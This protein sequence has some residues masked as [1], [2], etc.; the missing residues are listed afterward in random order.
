VALSIAAAA[1]MAVVSLVA[2]VK[3][4]QADVQ[5]TRAE[6]EAQTATLQREA[7]LI[8]IEA[9]EN[10]T[11]AL[12]RAVAAANTNLGFDKAGGV[13]LL[14]EIR[15]SLFQALDFARELPPL[16]GFHDGGYQSVKSISIR[17]ATDASPPRVSIASDNVGLIAD[18]K[19]RVVAR[20]I[21]VP[22]LGSAYANA[23]IWTDRSAQALA[24][25]ATGLIDDNGPNNAAVGL[26][27]AAGLLQRRVLTD[28]PFPILSLATL[29]LSHALLAGDSQGSLF[30]IDLA[31]GGV[32]KVYQGFGRPLIGI[33]APDSED[34][35]MLAFGSRLEATTSDPTPSKTQ[36]EEQ[37]AK[38]IAA[39]LETPELKVY[40]IGVGADETINCIGEGAGYTILTCDGRGGVAVWKD[41]YAPAWPSF[42]LVNHISVAGGRASAVAYDQ[43]LD[44][45]A[46]GDVDGGIQIFSA[47]G[48]ALTPILR[49]PGGPI[50]ALA[51]LENG[52]L[53]L[54][55]GGDSSIRRWD[56][57][58]LG[59]REANSPQ[60]PSGGIN[61][62]V[63]NGGGT[64]VFAASESDEG[65]HVTLLELNDADGRATS[66]KF[67][68]PPKTNIRGVKL[69]VD[70]AGARAAWNEPQAIVIVDFAA[71]DKSARLSVP[72]DNYVSSLVIT[73][74]GGN[75]LVGLKDSRQRLR[76]LATPAEPPL[77]KFIFYRLPKDVSQTSEIGRADDDGKA[78]TT[79]LI[80]LPAKL[81]SILDG[82][83]AYASGAAT[84]RSRFW[85]DDGRPLSNL[86]SVVSPEAERLAVRLIAAPQN[87]ELLL[88]SLDSRDRD[89]FLT[90][91]DSSRLAVWSTHARSDFAP[92][93]HATRCGGAGLRRGESEHHGRGDRGPDR[94]AIARHSNFRWRVHDPSGQDR[95]HGSIQDG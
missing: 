49:H 50:R 8:K 73:P 85:S 42:S 66:R 51:F 84:G 33:A 3:W 75:L 22:D 54:S 40:A 39:A 67:T 95:C 30:R 61:L 93:F 20:P 28:N 10:P 17:E 21:S 72:P 35:L 60:L 32:K 59:G 41:S 23:A 44:V 90:R 9:N 83:P 11:A 87:G 68:L 62:V 4:R 77:E 24:A 79:A 69:A 37:E 38:D 15:S 46:I 29:P 78:P 7:A 82:H 70:Q 45:I 34:K 13:A 57:S 80:G 71:D 55:A 31:D 43:P 19:G 53:L 1:V 89:D 94:Q 74:D 56:L 92:C 25:V 2:V 14:P 27:D 16:K 76:S 36:F 65:P 6:R 26:Y 47:L 5:F 81:K 63:A 48:Q 58:D 12:E 64:R 52:T 91:V 86:V 88:M 18:T